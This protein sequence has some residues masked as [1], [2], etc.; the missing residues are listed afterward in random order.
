MRAAPAALLTATALALAATAAAARDPKDPQQRHTAADTKLAQALALKQ[1]DLAAGW[2]P[3]KPSPNPPP[4]KTEPD[5]SEL[6][7]TARIDPTF[8]W[9]D[10]VTTLGSEVDVFKTAPMAQTDWN[11]STLTLFRSCLLQSARDQLP[12]YTVRVV[13]AK[14]LPAP[15]VPAQRALHYQLVFAISH[16]GRTVPIVSDVIA[17]GRGRETVVMH[18]FSVKTPLP[19]SAVTQLT[20]LLA[21][22]LGTGGI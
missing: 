22:R 3:E 6:V 4:C 15:A 13:S 9:K 5:E 1:S 2:K 8:V 14:R 7:Q 10:G 16:A 19:A 12:N 18:S 20:Q 11:L 17:L 21:S